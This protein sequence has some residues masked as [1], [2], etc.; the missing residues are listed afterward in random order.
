[1]GS[2]PHTWRIL[3][4]LHLR[5]YKPRDHLHT[6]GE[7]RWSLSR[8]WNATGITSTHVENTS[9]RSGRPKSFK[10]H[11]HTRG[12]YN[13][14]V[15]ATNY[16]VGSPPHTWRILSFDAQSAED[17]GITSTHVENTNSEVGTMTE[18]KDHLHTRGEYNSFEY[19]SK[20]TIG[21]PPH[22]WRIQ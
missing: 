21:S 5:C 9:W 7:Y 10:D 2:P 14:N 20:R 1:M 12:E 6:R 16:E 8:P 18:R 3:G 15:Y 19:I 22:T 11:L 13:Q 4:R 17:L